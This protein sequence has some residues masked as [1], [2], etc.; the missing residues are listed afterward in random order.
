[1]FFRNDFDEDGFIEILHNLKFAEKLRHL[2]IVCRKTRLSSLILLFLTPIIL[3]LKCLFSMKLDFH[4]YFS[5]VSLSILNRNLID[6]LSLEYFY[7]NIFLN[8]KTSVVDVTL[9][10]SWNM[11]GRFDE[12]IVWIWNQYFKKRKISFFLVQ[13][14]KQNDTIKFWRN[15][16]HLDILKYFNIS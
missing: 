13:I 8:N 2:E 11:N 16:I 5:L 7:S 4:R 9:D 3:K 1:M 6:E 12:K 14:M 10:F 15:L